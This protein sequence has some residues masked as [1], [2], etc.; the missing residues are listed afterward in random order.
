VRAWTGGY[1]KLAFFA[2]VDQKVIAQSPPGK[3]LCFRRVST[4]EARRLI[5]EEEEML[6]SIRGG[7]AG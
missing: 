4:A 6:A 1:R 5:R 3:R 7:P 2:S